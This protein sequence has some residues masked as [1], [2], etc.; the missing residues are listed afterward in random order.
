MNKIAKQFILVGI[1][2]GGSGTGL[3]TYYINYTNEP[4][5]EITRYQRA[6]EQQAHQSKQLERD[7]E[8]ALVMPSSSSGS[9]HY[10]EKTGTTVIMTTD[11]GIFFD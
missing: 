7:I 9:V 8:Q 11:D 2:V 1:L 6:K 5:S 3:Y 4:L 10:N